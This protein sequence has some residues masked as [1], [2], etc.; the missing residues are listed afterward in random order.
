MV[1][2]L[3]LSTSPDHVPASTVFL[4][5]VGSPKKDIPDAGDIDAAGSCSVSI[6]KRFCPRIRFEACDT[7]LVT[8]K[9]EM[10]DQIYGIVTL[11]APLSAKPPPFAF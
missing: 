8:A 5:P 3:L 11:N 9:S 7:I 4:E 2:S 10:W 6:V 1:D